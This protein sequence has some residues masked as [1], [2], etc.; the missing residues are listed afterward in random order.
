MKLDRLGVDFYGGGVVG[1]G[2]DGGGKGG[3]SNASF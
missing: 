1:W 2:G 3:G